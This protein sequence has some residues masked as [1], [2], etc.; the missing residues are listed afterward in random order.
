M[1]VG[2]GTVVAVE[3]AVEET[4]GAEAEDDDAENADEE[5]EEENPEASCSPGWCE[6]S[7]EDDEEEEEEEAEDALDPVALVYVGLLLLLIG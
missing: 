4:E 1:N 6:L 2:V 3:L 5:D 7:V